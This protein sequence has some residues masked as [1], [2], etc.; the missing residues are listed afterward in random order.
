MYE[1]VAKPTVDEFLKGYNG[2]IMV[3]GQVGAGK[4]FTMT[5]DVNVSI[6]EL[7][8]HLGWCDCELVTMTGDMGGTF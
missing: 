8:C 5:G 4:T 6:Q 2:T 1:Q 3:Y 7:G